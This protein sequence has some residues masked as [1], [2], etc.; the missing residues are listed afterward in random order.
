MNDNGLSLQF[1]VS[2]TPDGR[3]LEQIAVL[4]DTA[5]QTGLALGAVQDHPYNPQ[6]LGTW[7]LGFDTFIFWPLVPSAEQFRRFAPDVAHRT[8]DLVAYARQQAQR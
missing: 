4:V 3:D 8:R 5:D 2:V 7:M 6:F 1:G